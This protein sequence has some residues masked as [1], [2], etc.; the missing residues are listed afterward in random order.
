MNKYKENEVVFNTVQNILPDLPP[1]NI[2]VM[3][4]AIKDL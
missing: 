2:V 4:D 1:E 3:F